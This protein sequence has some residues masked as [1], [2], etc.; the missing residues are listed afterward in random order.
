MDPD[1]LALAAV[2]VV[3]LFGWRQASDSERLLEA[4]DQL[5]RRI[6][7]E[8]ERTRIAA[9]TAT[10]AAES[11]TVKPPP[12]LVSGLPMSAWHGEPDWGAAVQSA[13]R[14]RMDPRLLDATTGNVSVSPLP[15]RLSL[16]MS[17]PVVTVSS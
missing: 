8:L 7:E 14:R 6:A 5:P 2:V 15:M 10:T 16:G 11:I 1:S 13:A 4:L 9:T 12:L 17:T 3:I